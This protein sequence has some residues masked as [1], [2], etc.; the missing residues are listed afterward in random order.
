MATNVRN[1][2]KGNH[3]EVG[4]Q[5]NLITFTEGQTLEYVGVWKMELPYAVAV[6]L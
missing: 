5:S 1:V 4:I 3:Q 6:I 2:A